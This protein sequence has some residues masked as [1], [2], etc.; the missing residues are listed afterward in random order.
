VTGTLKGDP[1]LMM[2]TAVA[3]NA[4]IRAIGCD[5]LS[6][7]GQQVQVMAEAFDAN[8]HP[9]ANPGITWETDAPGMATVDL[10]GLVTAMGNGTAHITATADD[11]VASIE[12]VVTQIVTS[13]TVEPPRLDLPVGGQGQLT[14]RA[15]DANGH[16]IPNAAF[17]WMSL[18]TAIARVDDNGL[19]TGV[20]AGFTK[21]RIT[22][23]GVVAEAGIAVRP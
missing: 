18:D 6:A 9:V 11:A 1:I 7:V 21:V 3:R 20:S 15:F 23:D 2:P 12:V 10:A 5:T 19:V 14:A 13:V 8:G 22:S 4:G 17:T 16:L